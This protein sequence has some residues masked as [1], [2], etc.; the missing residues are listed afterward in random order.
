MKY[1]VV[2][3][4]VLHELILCLKANILIIYCMLY[5]VL[6]LMKLIWNLK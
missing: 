3:A 5:F 2:I 6:L 4:T 1:V